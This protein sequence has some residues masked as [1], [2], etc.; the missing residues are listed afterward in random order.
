MSLTKTS[1]EID[2]LR[3]G[4]LLL[5]Q[6]LQAAVDAVKPGVTIRS[7]DAIATEVIE[8]GGG[9]P[10]FRGYK[11]GG[12]IPFPSTVCISVNDEIVHG[13]GNRNLVLK[14]GDIVGLDIGLWLENLATDMAVTVPVGNISQERLALLRLTRDSMYAGLDAIKLG[15]NIS[16]IGDAIEDA[17]DGQYGIVTALVGHGVGHKVHEPPHIPNYRAGKAFPTVK[18]V[19]GMV[20]AIE[21]MLTTGDS[22]VTTADDGWTIKTLD[23]SDAAHFEVTVAITDSG[24]EIL[25]PQPKVRI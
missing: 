13:L 6:A 9:K 7:L 22:D 12:S 17:V 18:I 11:A 23:G 19:P 21:P 24:L 2:S 10:S 1:T 4:G 16:D 3:R 20:L 14:E 25:T 8:K 5:S 15:G